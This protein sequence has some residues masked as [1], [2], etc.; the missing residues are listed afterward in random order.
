MIDW[1]WKAFTEGLEITCVYLLM[2]AFAASC[3]VAVVIG[4]AV[5]GLLH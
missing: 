4:L 5:Y 3:L 2:L 1:L